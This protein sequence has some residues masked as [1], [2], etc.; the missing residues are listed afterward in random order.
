MAQDNG[1]VM[2]V[3]RAARMYERIAWLRER[4]PDEP[5]LY[6]R[7]RG[8]F[9]HELEANYSSEE[10]C[11]VLEEANRLVDEATGVL[12]QEFDHASIRYEPQINRLRIGFNAEQLGEAVHG[13]AWGM[14]VKAL[15]AD[16]NGET[17]LEA[18]LRKVGMQGQRKARTRLEDLWE[19]ASRDLAWTGFSIRLE[20]D[21]WSALMEPLEHTGTIEEQYETTLFEN[22]LC[23]LRVGPQTSG[24]EV[25]ATMVLRETQ[26]RGMMT[27]EAQLGDL[28]ASIEAMLKA[29]EC[30]GWYV[31]EEIHGKEVVADWETG[32]KEMTYEAKAMRRARFEE[33]KAGLEASAAM[34]EPDAIKDAMITGYREAL[35]TA[36]EVQKSY[37]AAIEAMADRMEEAA[38]YA[39]TAPVS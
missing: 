6:E 29:P 38:D 33:I 10:E 11:T 32:H 8:G 14:L 35:A 36:D 3:R 34:Y 17:W 16:G 1:R 39:A 4:A 23:H 22:V 21:G 37:M 24:F 27:F 19:S 12:G 26:T 20:E 5:V 9:V 7:S 15:E 2:A 31:L 13:R 25:T 28:G 18:T 30:D